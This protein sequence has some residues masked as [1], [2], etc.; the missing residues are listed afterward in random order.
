MSWSGTV[1]HVIRRGKLATILTF[2]LAGP[3]A[4]QTATIHACRNDT[5]GDLRYVTGPG[6]CRQ[7]ETAVSWTSGGSGVNGNGTPGTVPLWSGSGSTLANSHIHDNGT[8]VNIT[9][10]VSASHAGP[11]PTINGFSTNGVGVAGRST[12]NIGVLGGTSGASGGAAAVAGFAS[13]SSSPCAS[14]GVSGF[15][16]EGWGTRGTAKSG[17]GVEGISSTGVGVRGQ[18]LSCDS[19]GCTPTAGDA[20]QFVTGAG[21][22]LLRGF[23]SHS[24]T[25]GGWEEKFVVDAAGNLMTYGDAYKPGGGSWSMLSDARTK[26]SIEPIGK[27]LA[28]LLELRGVTYEYTN[29]SAFHE[30]PGTQIGMVAQDVERVFPSWVDTA[31]DGYKRLTFRGFEAV[32]VEAVRELDAKSRD[33]AARIAELERQNAELRHAIEEL[34]AT[35]KTLQRR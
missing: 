34:S 11:G 13:C 18:L 2:S 31:K 9:L 5:N 35:V 24:N 10:P 20:G 22:I 3:A 21:G 19:S 15:A 23:L 28:Q 14:T 25:P 8:L 12:N 32:A 17:V 1:G 33:A 30:R 26:K 4:A 16:E 27:A 6:Q 7:H 29:P